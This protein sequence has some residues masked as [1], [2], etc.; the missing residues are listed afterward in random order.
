MAGILRKTVGILLIIF[1][2]ILLIL[3]VMD[4]FTLIGVFNNIIPITLIGYGVKTAFPFVKLPLGLGG[5]LWKKVSKFLLYII[6]GI[7]VGFIVLLMLPYITGF[8]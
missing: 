7:I 4:D 8:L 6:L 3:F 2:V 5:G 1:G